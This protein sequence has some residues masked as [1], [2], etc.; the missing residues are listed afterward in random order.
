MALSSCWPWTWHQPQPSCVECPSHRGSL[1]HAALSAKAPSRKRYLCTVSSLLV[2]SG[3]GILH[4]RAA[5]SLQQ[6][7]GQLKECCAVKLACLLQAT[8]LTSPA[9][10]FEEQRAPAQQRHPTPQAHWGHR[11]HPRLPCGC[12]FAAQVTWQ[13]RAP[14]W[15]HT[16]VHVGPFWRA[17]ADARKPGGAQRGACTVAGA[18]RS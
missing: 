4:E 8:V 3:C 11:G 10:V 2:P 13:I 15:W 9:M 7:G 17:S 14:A 1:A 6:L 16:A 12:V 5:W 18:D